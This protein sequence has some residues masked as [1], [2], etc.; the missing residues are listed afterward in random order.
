MQGDNWVLLCS[1]GL[2]TVQSSHLLCF[3]H[4]E[5]TLTPK[6]NRPSQLLEHFKNGRPH[7]RLTLDE[8]GIRLKRFLLQHFIERLYQI[9]S[10]INL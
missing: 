6:L 7:F 4:A 2:G 10:R 3:K 9:P 5:S 8:R 1:R